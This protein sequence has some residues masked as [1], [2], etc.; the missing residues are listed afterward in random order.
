M[1]TRNSIYSGIGDFAHL[2]R[3]DKNWVT[4]E[5]IRSFSLHHMSAL[6]QFIASMRAARIALQ[7]GVSAF[8]SHSSKDK[9][10]VRSLAEYL[11]SHGIRV[12]LDEADLFGGET[13]LDRLASA[14][15]ETRFIIVIL[16]KYSVDSPWVKKELALAQTS[17]VNGQRIK[18]IPILK[19]DCRIPIQLR[20]QLYLDFRTPSLRSKNRPVLVDAI[21][22][23]AAR[24]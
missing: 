20:K 24:D 15:H 6:D 14:V 10:F 13:L 23:L 7:G 3:A 4:S 5:L 18:V 9:K 17:E 22:Q 2:S 12:W 16:S 19:D 1:K 21:M 11:Q 8:L